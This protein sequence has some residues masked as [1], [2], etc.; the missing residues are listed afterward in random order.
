MCAI[1]IG[2][3]LVTQ[4]VPTATISAITLV[5]SGG[6]HIGL[7]LLGLHLLQWSADIIIH[8]TQLLLKV[9]LIHLLSKGSRTLRKSAKVVTMS[10]ENTVEE[11]R[12]RPVC[13][14]GFLFAVS[15]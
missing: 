5:S 4:S 2:S 8:F 14:L 15:I 13:F 1:C 9:F 3:S 7:S 11:Q 10:L 12:S 6:C